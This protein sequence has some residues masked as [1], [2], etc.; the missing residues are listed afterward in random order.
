MTLT[1][2]RW[3][4]VNLSVQ[5]AVHML[6]SVATVISSTVVLNSRYILVFRNFFT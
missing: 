4:D 6:K 1:D 5:V 3:E 2:G